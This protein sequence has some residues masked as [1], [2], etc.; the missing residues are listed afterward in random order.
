MSTI[1]N[2]LTPEEATWLR[3]QATI[4]ATRIAQPLSAAIDDLDGF[5]NGLLV[6]VAQ[7]VPALLQTNP[8]VGDVLSAQWKHAAERYEA[9]SAG[10]APGAEDEPLA[11]LEARHLLYRACEE[12]GLWTASNAPPLACS[13]RPVRSQ[14]RR[15]LRH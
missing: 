2:T 4:S 6:V 3:L 13:A 8:T 12:R 9:M 7:L 10:E 14:A 15:R 1:P 5:L 11:Q